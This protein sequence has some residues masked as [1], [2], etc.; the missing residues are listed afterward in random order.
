MARK[1]AQP[2]VLLVTPDGDEHRATHPAELNNLVF[3]SG[4]RLKD[5]K[6]SVD[7]AIA[8][9]AEGLDDDGHLPITAPELPAPA[10]ASAP[11]T[12]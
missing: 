2:H 3:G 11:A 10:P 4:Y 5:A 1:S 12:K 6:L 9:L 7:E 8:S